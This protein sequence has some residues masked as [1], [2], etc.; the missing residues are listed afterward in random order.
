MFFVLYNIKGN[1]YYH[2]TDYSALSVDDAA[3][4]HC[5]LEAQEM[6]DILNEGSNKIEWIYVPFN[7]NV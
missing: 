6:A 3:R 2:Q 4:Y 1:H 7:D 5:S